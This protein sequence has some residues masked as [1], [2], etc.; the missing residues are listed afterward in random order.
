M[1]F[2]SGNRLHRPMLVVSGQVE[3]ETLMSTYNIPGLRQLGD[4]EVDIVADGQG[5]HEIRDHGH[6]PVHYPLSSF[7]RAIYSEQNMGDQG[8]AG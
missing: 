6:G 1:A 3:R 8:R 2:F 7:E 5:N 4:Q